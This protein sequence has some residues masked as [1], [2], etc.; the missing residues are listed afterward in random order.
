MKSILI[1]GALGFIG[2]AICDFLSCKSDKVLGVDAGVEF[3][4]NKKINWERADLTDINVVA[5]ICKKY[6]PDMVIHCAGIAHQKMGAVDA[7]TYMR[8]N[9]EA[10]ENL[11][12]SAAG[13]PDLHF[14]FLSTT[15][16]YGEN[17][18]VQPVPEDAVCSPSSDYAMSKLDAEK[19]LIRLY[20]E[21]LFRKL[22]ILRLA[23]VYDREWGFNL[24]RRVF[25]PKKFVYL[26]FGNG[27]QGISALARPNL[28]ELMGHLLKRPSGN[29]E[30]EIMNVCDIEPY[31]F[32]K[33]IE[34]FQKSGIYP[35]RPTMTIPFPIVW[36]TTRIAGFIM[37]DKRDW[38]HSCYNKLALNLVFNN[39]KMIQTGF[40]P[41]HSLETVFIRKK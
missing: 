36:S 10:T 9:S 17:H 23:P 16:V 31:S 33:I 18:I 29:R 38:L 35:V 8:V 4:E 24:E 28:V 30:I 15:A 7:A 2:S 11:A 25:A 14:I 12:R 20:E 27:K 39:S 26:K 13:N 19:R 37:R 32:N 34:T 5:I 6:F 22:T 1:T 40:K 21:G 41:S 3:L